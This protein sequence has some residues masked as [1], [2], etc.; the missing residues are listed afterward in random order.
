[1]SHNNL[2]QKLW[3]QAYSQH[4]LDVVISQEEEEEIIKDMIY[5]KK[6]QPTTW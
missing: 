4:I 2:Q 6:S 1:M 3:E 5:K